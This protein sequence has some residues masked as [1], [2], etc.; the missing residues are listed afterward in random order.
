MTG[1]SFRPR[2]PPWSLDPQLAAGTV[3]VGYLALSRLLLTNDVNYP[4]LVL[5]PRRPAVVELI[6]LEGN[7]QTQLLAE[8]DRLRVP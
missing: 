1:K 6:D 3:P 5:A 2:L 8:V 7:E 4:W